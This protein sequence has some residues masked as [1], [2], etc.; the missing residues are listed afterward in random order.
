MQDF[1][2]FYCKLLI[3]LYS[4]LSSLKLICSS[5]DAKEI[6]YSHSQFFHKSMDTFLKTIITYHNYYYDLFIY[7]RQNCK[8]LVKCNYN[9]IQLTEINY[10]V[11]KNPNMEL[12]S[13]KILNL[14]LRQYPSTNHFC[15]LLPGFI[16]K[17]PL[18]AK[19]P[20]HVM[21]QFHKFCHILHSANRNQLLG[22]Q[23]PQH[24]VAV[25]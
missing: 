14:I 23:K 24:G 12:L 21:P 5:L 19:C 2:N 17:P 6:L 18:A 9:N 22:A 11:H 8:I 4:S 1:V 10:L 13:H 25:T 7:S 15:E 3:C 16:R 20:V